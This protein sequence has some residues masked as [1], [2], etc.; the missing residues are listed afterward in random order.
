M[1]DK[2]QKSV[3]SVTARSPDA[4]GAGEIL[5]SIEALRQM[6]GKPLSEVDDVEWLRKAVDTLWSLLDDVDTADDIAKG[7]DE[8]YRK[9]AY[10]AQKKRFEV[11]TSDGYDL[12]LPVAKDV[13]GD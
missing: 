9:L 11:L 1:A 8:L 12:F 7:N 13:E 2:I 4:V 10:K 6:F 3:E 5:D